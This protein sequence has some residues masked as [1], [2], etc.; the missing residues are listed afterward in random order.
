MK[1]LITESKVREIGLKW[2]ND[3][4][5]PDQ[6]EIVK[7]PKYPDDSI[8]YRKNGQVVMEQ[9][10][11]KKNFYFDYDEI[12][13]FFESFFGMKYS[14]IEQLMEIWLEET[15][16]LKGYTPKFDSSFSLIW[17]EETLNLEGYTPND[18][19]ISQMF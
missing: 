9:D 12:W 11:K 19:G 17:L 3:N 4:F 10:L 13:L 18:S 15:L 5:S 8:F 16:N 1:Y 6:L 2:M 7:S 14:E